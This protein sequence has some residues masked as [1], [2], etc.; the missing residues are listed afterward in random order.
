[1]T[2]TGQAS[3][4][5]INTAENEDFFIYFPFESTSSSFFKS[6]GANKDSIVLNVESMSVSDI[7]VITK[8][9]FVKIFKYLTDL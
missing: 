5:N 8:N 2:E 9:N 4:W 3:L 6:S 7:T 1:M